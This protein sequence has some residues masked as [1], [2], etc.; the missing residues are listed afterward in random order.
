MTH[1]TNS[2][3]DKYPKGLICIAHNSKHDSETCKAEIKAS[4]S[5]QGHYIPIERSDNED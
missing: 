5:G 3:N 1:W 4:E 2:N